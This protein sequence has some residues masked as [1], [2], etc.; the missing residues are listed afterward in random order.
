MQALTEREIRASFVNCSRG[1]ATRL[2]LPA[3]DDMPW[4]DL[5]FL[6]WVDPKAP[7]DAAVVVPVEDRLVGVKLRRNHGMGGG[8]TRMCSWCCTVHPASGVA[9]MVAQ[10]A[11]K[12]GR[13]G[14]STGVDVCADL[15]CSGYVRG[16][17]PAPV[18]GLV[19]ETTPVEE[20]T[21]RLRRNLDSFLR[22]VLR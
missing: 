16:W 12:A 10:R 22:R 18:V 6:G 1:E 3:L 13:D 4:P 2:H 11:G 21:E 20:K 8:G 7:L 14:N 15:R 17:A 5:D 19:E 9:L